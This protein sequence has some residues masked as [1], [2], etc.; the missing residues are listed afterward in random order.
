[1]INATRTLRSKQIPEHIKYF[2]SGL[3]KAVGLQDDE[4][5]KPIVGVIHGWNEMGPGDFH[6]KQIADLIKSSIRSSG[7][8][9]VEIIVPGLCAGMSNGTP[10][11]GYSLPY[12][13]FAAG[14]VE[15]MLQGYVCD[16]AVVVPTCDYTVPA[17][18]MGLAR[19]DIPSVVVTGGYM[20][21]GEYQGR[22]VIMTD[23]K[24]AY[25]QYKAG[26]IS[27]E[28]LKA[29][30]NNV[31]PTVGGCP[32]LGTASTMCSM[33]EALGMSLPENATTPAQSSRLFSIAKRAGKQVMQLIDSDTRPS[34]IL[35]EAAFRNAMTAILAMGGSTNAVVHMIAMAREAGIRLDLESWDEMS[36]RTPFICRLMPNHP[37]NTMRE[38]DK[39]GGVQALMK[40]LQP[41]LQLD[42]L[43][44]TGKTLEENLQHAQVLDKEIIR[45]IQNPYSPEGGLAVLKGNLAP[46]G[47]VVKVSAV[48]SSMLKHSGPARV[49]NSEEDAFKALMGN[50]IK[51][52]NVMVI[53]Y[54][55]PRGAPGAP[56]PV[57]VMH[58][59]I[60][61]GLGDSVALVSDSRF[62]GT[63][64]GAFIAHVSPEAAAGGPIA[65]VTDGDVIEID[66]PQRKLELRL[67]ETEI[68]CRLKKW[69][70]PRPRV[71]KG[72]LALYAK[73]ARSLSEG[74]GIPT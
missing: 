59:I 70:P 64:K 11:S 31:C 34:N 52:G 6:L 72:V 51:P 8:T 24:I 66:I 13:D 17:Y 44:V 9:P 71:E 14:M 57:S 5:E 30:A 20:Q 69:T 40:E 1:M 65:I 26:K 60:G 41:L 3:L 27:E 28:E 15:I 35:T 54:E 56:E 74:G 61:L 23:V 36:R 68:Q 7:G 42:V 37:S 21:P 39:A 18:L 47:A 16:G 53:R 67:S 29:L 38:F 22:P 55:G 73:V 19:V 45:S 63:N 50:E 12:R 4:M 46:E 2:R 49:F 25:G 10:F 33:I 58:G 48:P 43:T 32:I 62:S